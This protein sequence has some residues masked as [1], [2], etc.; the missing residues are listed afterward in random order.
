MTLKRK[1]LIQEKN[2]GICWSALTDAEKM[3]IEVGL[4]ELKEGK[5]IPAKKAV[6]HLIK[7][8]GL[9]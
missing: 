7:K 4:R 6:A 9:S 8:Y 3:K 2:N 1:K 5:G